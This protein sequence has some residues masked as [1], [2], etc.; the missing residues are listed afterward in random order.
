MACRVENDNE[1]SS[2]SPVSVVE[3][4]KFRSVDEYQEGKVCT[5]SGG[6][7]V[8]GGAESVRLS[9]YITHALE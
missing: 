7:A 4:L 9:L 2:S 3:T 8:A 1:A 6:L 5:I